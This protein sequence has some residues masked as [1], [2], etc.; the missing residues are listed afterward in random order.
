MFIGVLKALSLKSIEFFIFLL[1]L[2]I[3]VSQNYPK[4]LQLVNNKNKRKTFSECVRYF[5]MPNA[6]NLKKKN[7]VRNTTG[8]VRI[9][10]A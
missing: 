10:I 9:Y 1:E 2:L 3:D 7:T 6:F 8:Y 4:Y 5:Y